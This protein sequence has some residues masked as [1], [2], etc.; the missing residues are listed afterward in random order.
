M[1]LFDDLFLM[2]RDC[3]VAPTLRL[4][5]HLALLA[6]AAQVTLCQRTY[7]LD[8]LFLEIDSN[9]FAAVPH[10]LHKFDQVWF[11]L[12]NLNL[13]LTFKLF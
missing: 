1:Y 8:C 2:V 13:D 12:V 7:F 4:F 6:L 9:F 11:C 5:I 3:I 10:A